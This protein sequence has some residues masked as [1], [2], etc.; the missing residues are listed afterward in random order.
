MPHWLH[1]L[2]KLSKRK[3]KQMKDLECPC[4]EK[5]FD[6]YDPI[7]VFDENKE[8]EQICPHCHEEV[9]FTVSFIPFYQPKER[10][11]Q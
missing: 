10:L 11:K 8:Y 4:C 9:T 5:W 3:A 1:D 2:K 6:I 7:Y